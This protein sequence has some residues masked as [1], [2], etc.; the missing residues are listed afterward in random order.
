MSDTQTKGFGR[1]MEDKGSKKMLAFAAVV[2]VGGLGYA[3]LG[4]GGSSKA[5]VSGV[6]P[7][8]SAIAATGD[9]E[10][11]ISEAY[12]RATAIEDDNRRK[13][14]LLHN[15]SFTPSVPPQ[16]SALAL[17]AGLD[18]ADLKGRAE[19]LPE[20]PHPPTLAQPMPT[21]VPT[22][23]QVAQPKPVQSVDP[24]V[25]NALRTQMSQMAD[26]PMQAAQTQFWSQ[27]ATNPPPTNSTTATRF[28]GAAAA[29]PIIAN[30]T[31]AAATQVRSRFVVPAT[32]TILYSRLIGKVNSDTPG[33]IVAEIM[34]GPYTGARLIGTFQF[35]ENGVIMNFS[36]MTV[37][38]NEDGDAKTEVVAIKAVAVDAAN[39][40]TAM[41]T[42]IERHIFERV[43]VAA[44]TSFMQGFGQA[45]SQ[46]GATA[47]T[48]AIGGTTVSNPLLS[49]QSQLFMAGGAAA[50]ATGQVF[51][52]I[53]G[54]RRT[55]VTVDA[56]TPFGLLFLG[57]TN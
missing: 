16:N 51:Q 30:P 7:P 28:P 27:T 33:P 29:I 56:D 49:T 4:S 35:S 21:Y 53:Y 11:P 1:L 40:G 8:P 5:E 48:N 24:N 55:T 18:G 57:T 45:I 23:V 44:A 36:S 46:S 2:V 42:D 20:R 12:K 38:F 52:Q 19:I 31:V 54:N 14:A 34:Q 39:L 17:N 32:G 3:V 37:P 50:A 15:Q 43:A 47:T 41:S 13:E 26:A 9:A 6:R 25:V 10:K 22:P